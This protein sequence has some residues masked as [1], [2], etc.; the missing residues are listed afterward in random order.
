MKRVFTK[1]LAYTWTIPTATAILV[2]F[3]PVYVAEEDIII[4]GWEFSVHKPVGDQLMANDGVVD[5]EAELEFQTPWLAPGNVAFAGCFQRWNTAPA[6]GYSNSMQASQMLPQGCGISMREGE[7]IEVHFYGVNTTS[8]DCR[9][10]V[11][12]RIYYI[13]GRLA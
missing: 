1:G 10:T 6:F 13:K 5:F 12:A 8:A 11:D 4:I 7:A 3:Q 2:D 9:A